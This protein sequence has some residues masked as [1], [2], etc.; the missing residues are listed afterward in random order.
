MG[1]LHALGEIY[2]FVDKPEKA[3]LL[4]KEVFGRTR[5]YTAGYYLVASYVAVGRMDEANSVVKQNPGHFSASSI[6]LPKYRP[7]K[8][9]ADLQR[10]LDD[11]AKA[12]VE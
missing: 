3:I 11:L 9:Q 6:L 5:W 8:N 4:M 2:Y 12:G 1:A 7:F 10:V